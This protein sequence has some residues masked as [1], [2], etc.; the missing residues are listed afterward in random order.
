MLAVI[1][2]FYMHSSTID[3]SRNRLMLFYCVMCWKYVIVLSKLAGGKPSE[4]KGDKKGENQSEIPN[5]NHLQ[6]AGA[7][8]Y[9]NFFKNIIIF[10]I[11]H[12]IPPSNFNE[13]RDEKLFD[14]LRLV[15]RTFRRKNV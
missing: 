15:Q 7:M 14:G 3:E 8:G 13:C 2:Y 1:I 10:I 11:K 4:K 12:K 6:G 9:E 5:K